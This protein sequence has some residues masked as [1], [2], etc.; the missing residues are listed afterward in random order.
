MDRSAD[1]TIQG[2]LY[3]FNKTL[4]EVLSAGDTDEITIEGPIE[5]VEVATVDGIRA[6][7]CKYHEAKDGFALSSIYKP[8][9]QMM[10]HFQANASPEVSYVLFA[11][12]P[13]E[14]GIKELEP[15]DLNEAVASK[16]KNL[17]K[18][19]DQLREFTGHELFLKRFTLQFGPSYDDLVKEVHEGL[20]NAGF[21]HGDIEAL[22]YPNA[23]HAIALLST[24]HEARERKTTKSKLVKE[25][26]QIKATAISRW[27]LMLKSRKQI[28]TARRAQLKHQFDKNA[29]RRHLLV[30]ETAVENFHG[31]IVGFIAEFVGK[32]YF[33]PS[34]IHPPLF[35]LDIPEK[36]FREVQQGLYKKGIIAD[37]GF[38]GG[39]FKEERF[40]REPMQ[41]NK[42]REK[43][44]HIRLARW[45]T[46][47]SVLRK[48]NPDDVFV[49][50]MQSYS[51]PSSGGI[52]VIGSN[53]LKEISFIMGIS[54]AY[55]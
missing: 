4:V 6:I 2:F 11:H 19:C 41:K 15:A 54:N 14:A 39:E 32:F 23:L 49:L 7:Q 34:H 30:G 1:Y 3:Q 18:Y 27:T 38:I 9:L 28:L 40:F 10:V 29:R 51:G 46:Q 36:A 52:E 12:F 37:D 33:K 13:G 31:E 35:C 48:G 44:F 20:K 42:G 25:L 45:E 47:G 26:K 16:N 17:K 24:R 55:E 21:V 5:D 22:S 43:E 8:L 53:S 50:G